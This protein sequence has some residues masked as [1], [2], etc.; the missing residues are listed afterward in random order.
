M[1]TKKQTL[2]HKTFTEWQARVEE[3]ELA[4]RAMD[5][6]VLKQLLEEQYDEM[7]DLR[8]IEKKNKTS[9]RTQS[10]KGPDGRETVIIDMT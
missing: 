10:I 1:V 2:S 3:G 6:D 5:R 7:V 4:L 8:K 9:G